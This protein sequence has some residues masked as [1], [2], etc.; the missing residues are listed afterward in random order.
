MKVRMWPILL[1]VCVQPALAQDASTTE[2]PDRLDGVVMQGGMEHSLMPQGPRLS[3]NGKRV[4]WVSLDRYVDPR[5]RLPE[6]PEEPVAAVNER[7]AVV[8]FGINSDK[9]ANPEALG[10]L[11]F[12]QAATVRV[13]GYA[14]ATGNT[15]AN[16]LMSLRRAQEVALLIR[17]R[18][19]PAERIAIEGR[20]GEASVPG[21]DAAAVAFARRAEIIVEVN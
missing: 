7:R 9:P 19:V 21:A 15:R 20:G 14:N 8:F 10:I 12:R 11:P 6:A 18:G 5:Q 2:A 13:I 16:L 4:A 3:V 1:A 17:A